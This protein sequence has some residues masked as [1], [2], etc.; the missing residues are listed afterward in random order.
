M[1][2]RRR[3]RPIWTG[4][5]MGALLLALGMP[6]GAEA[7]TAEKVS[8]GPSYSCALTGTGALMCWGDNDFGYLGNA[9][10][11]DSPVPTPVSG[12]AGGA[13]DLD[14]GG[15]HT[16]AVDASGGAWC[17]GNNYAGQLGDGSLD[18]HDVPVSVSGLGSGVAAVAAGS[19]HSCAVTTGGGVLCWGRNG[20][21]QLGDGST[22]P[23]PVPVGV[24]GLASGVAAVA[25]G[26]NYSC[27]LT[28]AGAVLCWGGNDYV[29]GGVGASSV[30]VPIGGLG[31][32]V[33]AIS[34]YSNVAC[35]LL[36][37]GDVHCWGNNYAGQL[38]TPPD[39]GSPTPAA[40]AGLP[41]NI[42]SLSVGESHVCAG[43][44]AGGVWCWGENLYGQL[45]N[46]T[47]ADSYVPVPVSGLGAR[48]DSLAAGL[49]HTCAAT[50]QGA[51]FC[52]GY[53]P[54]GQIGNGSAMQQLLPVGVDGASAGVAS[55]AAG[56]HHSCAAVNG[57][58]LCW[59]D[60]GFGQLGVGYGT[61]VA[62]TPQ[63]VSG[64][65]SGVSRITAGASHT[66]ALTAGGAVSCW[67]D[68]GFGQVGDAFPPLSPVYT[69]F[70]LPSLAS[71]VVDLSAGS[72]HSCAA[73]AN[74][75]AR[76]WGANDAAQ[77]GDGT[78]TNRSTPVAVGGLSGDVVAIAGGRRHACAL[79]VGGDV[80]CWGTGWLGDGGSSLES[81]PVTVSGLSNVDAIAVGDDHSCALA[82]GAVSCWGENGNG[83]LGDG[84]TT[85]RDLPVSVSGLPGGIVAIAAGDDHTCAASGSGD[86]FCWGDNLQGQLGD[87]TTTDRHLPVAVAG[88]PGGV[89][90]LAGGTGHSCAIAATGSLWCWGDHSW[91]QL[92]NGPIGAWSPVAVVGFELPP[93]VPALGV[94]AGLLL[95]A[96]L[97]GAVRRTLRA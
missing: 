69:P 10:T 68:N 11:V 19:A 89:T 62:V 83:Q 71:G 8:V 87:G 85:D 75:E 5:W 58:A 79:I 53:G 18:S 20:D 12:F 21:G 14:A 60:N 54:D 34:A 6:P 64:L 50:V 26:N 86:A 3:R 96:G 9:S 66:C 59:G 81:P 39:L 15:G 32:G 52:W 42:V 44:E 82:A 1:R 51:L 16:C 55:I 76:C 22:T 92:G 41:A 94:F 27:A 91:G 37:G 25:L 65:S 67:G 35:A 13:T 84:T 7:E 97:A 28:D 38:G 30:P 80:Q 77:L 88:L 33:A 24:S 4:G 17:W 56:E 73:L 49:G 43:P 40:V 23:S 45:G 61:T 63:P 29:N 48:V 74:G 93:A 70:A 36:D 31:S 46:G 95:A 78:T 2:R 90:A 72:S 57:S 47:N